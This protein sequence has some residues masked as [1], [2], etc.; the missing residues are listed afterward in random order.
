MDVFVLSSVAEG[1]CN[2]LLEAMATGLPVVG[3]AVGGNPEIVVDGESGLL[4][5]SGDAT[6]LGGH[7]V[8]LRSESA[9]RTELGRR[10]L[11]RVRDEFSIETM[12]QAYD[13]LYWS[14]RPAARVSARLATS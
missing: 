3:T 9:L 8:R 14:L 2:S 1:I 10:A 4:F 11:Q 13:E 7:L 6:A 12:V 5:R